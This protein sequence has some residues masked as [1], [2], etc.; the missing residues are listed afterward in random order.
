MINILYAVIALGSLG[1]GFGLIL[2]LA[3]RIF[4]VD[5]DERFEPLIKALPGANCGGCG[6][7]SCSAYAEAVLDGNAEVNLCPVGGEDTAR[8]IAAIMEVEPVKSVRHTAL[9]KCSG[10]NRASKK[11]E[12]AGIGD[13]VSAMNTGGGP[14]ACRYG[15]LGLG[16]CVSAC[17]FGAVSVTEGVA[18]TDHERCTGCLACVKACPRRI[19]TM[20]P[21]LADVNVC[22]SSVDKGAVLRKVCE[23]GC[24]GC[25]MCEKA[26]KYDAIHVNNN[27][28]VIDYE[29]CTGC[30]D[31]AEKCP[32]KLIFDANLDKGPKRAAENAEQTADN[33]ENA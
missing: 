12:Y 10:G 16:T 7:T 20:V 11:F 2:A 19:I 3:S 29:K 8:A 5:H 24:I 26:C 1:L 4:A 13:C 17:A 30:G 32:R 27:L 14:L 25:R 31:C 33:G 22:C 28:A 9:V 15:C 6:Y 23:V 18:L 21:Y